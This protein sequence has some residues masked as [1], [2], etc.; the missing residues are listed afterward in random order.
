MNN[1][2]HPKQKDAP[3]QNQNNLIDEQAAAGLLGISPQTLRVW[4]CHRK[5]LQFLKIGRCVRYRQ[6]DIEA[7]LS[8]TIHAVD[9]A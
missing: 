9:A 7:F 5:H 6:S 4:R 2:L 1:G 8:G 3:M